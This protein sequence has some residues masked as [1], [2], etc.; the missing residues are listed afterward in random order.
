MNP[1]LE[2][3]ALQVV[4]AIACLVPLTAGPTGIL[5]G[6]GWMAHGPVAADLDSHFRYMSGIF[7]GVGL[8]FA[9][10][11]P[12]IETKGARM[13]MLVAFVVSWRARARAVMGTGR[14]AQPRQS[15]RAGHGTDRYPAARAVAGTRG[16]TVDAGGGGR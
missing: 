5:R 3:R 4:V 7:T 13:R 12:N 10:C 6:A 9:S 2:K 15:I 8:A 16:A 1:A 14:A 11:I